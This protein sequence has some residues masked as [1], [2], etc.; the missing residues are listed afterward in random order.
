MLRE[1]R[2]DTQQ[3]FVDEPRAGTAW[4][5]PPMAWLVM[6]SVISGLACELGTVEV[7][8]PIGKMV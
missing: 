5:D 3:V 8:G 2:Q 4:D 6:K 1:G 7:L